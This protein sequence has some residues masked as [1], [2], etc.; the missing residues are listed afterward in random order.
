M[1]EHEDIQPEGS[2]DGHLPGDYPEGKHGGNNEMSVRAAHAP[3]DE[4]DDAGKKKA[5]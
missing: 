4:P 2:T 1:A 5:T 3:E